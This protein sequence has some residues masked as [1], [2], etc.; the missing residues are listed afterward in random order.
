MRSHSCERL[1]S[2]VNTLAPPCLPLPQLIP[3]CSC[4]AC[5]RNEPEMCPLF[6]KAII[7][8]P[9]EWSRKSTRGDDD[10]SDREVDILDM[11]TRMQLQ[12]PF[13]STALMRV[14]PASYGGEDVVPVFVGRKQPCPWSNQFSRDGIFSNGDIIVWIHDIRQVEPGEEG[15]EYEVPAEL[16]EDDQRAVPLESLAGVGRPMS[17]YM[18]QVAVH[19]SSESRTRYRRRCGVVEDARSTL[20]LMSTSPKKAFP[21][22]QPASLDGQDC[23]R[24]YVRKNKFLCGTVISKGFRSPYSSGE[25]QD[26]R[27]VKRIEAEVVDI[28]TCT[29]SRRHMYQLVWKG[30]ATTLAAARVPREVDEGFVELYCVRQ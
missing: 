24:A 19:T 22:A 1:N 8:A 5:L 16:D 4:G 26:W 2:A 18:E 17:E 28:R 23:R 13:D 21:P 12:L 7:T 6:R 30:D 20:V 10:G 25:A 9:T 11:F 15:A 29:A 27:G 14:D 3:C